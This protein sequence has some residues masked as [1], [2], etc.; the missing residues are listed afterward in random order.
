[1]SLERCCC[2]QWEDPLS[3]GEVQDAAGANPDGCEG[4]GDASSGGRLSSKGRVRSLL[5]SLVPSAEWDTL[6]LAALGQSALQ[7]LVELYSEQA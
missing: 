7:G 2:V 5:A 3:K 6:D 4:R 1:M